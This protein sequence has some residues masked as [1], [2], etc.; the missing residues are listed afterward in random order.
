MLGYFASVKIEGVSQTVRYGEYLF[1]RDYNRVC[2]I[3]KAGVGPGVNSHVTINRD[4]SKTFRKNT[5]KSQHNSSILEIG[6]FFGN[7]V[8]G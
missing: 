1:Y 8:C 2:V 5:E 6:Y 7:M 3:T 4:V